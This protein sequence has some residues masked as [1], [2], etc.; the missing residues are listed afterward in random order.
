[1]LHELLT[2]K[3]LFRR[4]SDVETLALVMQA[5]A[6][7]PSAANPAVPA[8]LDAVCLRA[9]A[10]E[11]K[12]RFADCRELV[13]ALEPIVHELGF[14]APKLAAMMQDFQPEPESAQPSSVHP[15]KRRRPSPLPF[16]AAALAFVAGGMLVWWV[17]QSAAPV[18]VT[19]DL[20]ALPDLSVLPDL[21]TPSDLAVLRDL[22]VFPDLAHHHKK[23]LAPPPP[24]APTPPPAPTGLHGPV[25]PFAD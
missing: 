19:A 20:S 16:V 3:P 15:R 1:V 11:P 10:R 7:A 18:V 21:A 22:S 9:L 13:A 8:A 25:D 6:A 12:D 23:I 17:R 14:S 4:E 5:E 24:A 2:G